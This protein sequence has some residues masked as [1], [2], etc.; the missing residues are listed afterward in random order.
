VHFAIAMINPGITA[1]MQ[2]NIVKLMLSFE[3]M[4]VLENRYV[5]ANELKENKLSEFYVSQQA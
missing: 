3:M 2:Y 4:I 1:F 5:R